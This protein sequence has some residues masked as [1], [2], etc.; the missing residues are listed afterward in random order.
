MRILSVTGVFPPDT[1]TGYANGARDLVEALRRRGHEVRVLAARSCCGDAPGGDGVDRLLRPGVQRVRDWRATV[2]KEAVNQAAFTRVL[3]DFG[4]DVVL[5]FDLSDVS[6]S[7]GMLA[8]EHGVPV[9][10]RLATD[11]FVGWERDDWVRAWPKGA[12]G[13]RA[14]RYAAAKYGLHPPTAPLRFG[15]AIFASSFLAEIAH[16][17]DVPL[18]SSHV[19]PWGVDVDGFP[20][21]PGRAG[22]PLRLLAAGAFE[23]EKGFEVVIRAAARFGRAAGAGG[24]GFALTI[25]GQ[26]PCWPPARSAAFDHLRALVRELGIER[27][28][29]IRPAVPREEM[30]A[31]YRRHDVYVRAD[32]EEGAASLAV[33]EAMSSGLV[34]VARRTQG[35]AD[36]LRDGENAL[37]FDDADAAACAP[38]LSRLAADPGLFEN[39]REAGRRT[40]E[41]DHRLD[42]IAARV[43]RVL[44]EAAGRPSGARVRA[45][46]DRAPRPAAEPATETKAEPPVEAV[47]DELERRVQAEL[48]V[49]ALA[50]AAR[51]VARPATLFRKA[52][53]LAYKISAIGSL[54]VAPALLEAVFRFKG[55]RK[56]AAK[57]DRG[58]DGVKSVL[59]IQPADMGDVLLTSPFLRE[60]RRALP[61]AWIG[62]AVQPSMRAL[63]ERCPYVDEIIPFP[64]RTVPRWNDAFFGHPRW[65]LQSLKV[66]M[67][68]LWKRRIDLAVSVRWNDDA[69]QAAAV[70]LMVASG[71][72]RR[73]GYID[74]PHDRFRYPYANYNRLLTGGPVRRVLKPEAEIQLGVLKWLGAAVEDD[75]AEVWTSPADDEFA[76]AVLREGG[77]VDGEPV[78]AI[79]PGAA[80]APRRWPAERFIE[81]GRRLQDERG[82]RVVLLAAPV[83]RDLAARVAAGLRSDRTLNLAGRTGILQMAAVLRRCRLFLGNDSGPLHLAAAAGVPTVGIYGAGEYERFRPWGTNRHRVV[84]LGLTCSPCSLN[85]IFQDARCLRAIPVEKVWDAVVDLLDQG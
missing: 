82:A 81:V 36:V 31:I 8:R 9:C 25:L 42:E 24:G 43:E 64:W 70:T 34:V 71:A 51:A 73:V 11:W 13:A 56:G 65:W 40:V 21:R 20:F 80:W 23:P 63:V 28:V 84:N 49:A 50:V 83:E 10:S 74:F 38:L 35:G 67:K 6:A 77:I 48:R 44:D 69:P 53:K 68:R 12:G 19:I 29:R 5:A 1:P 41:L 60:L 4:P 47:V 3:R 75:R 18:E 52:R 46:A 14:L 61:K 58:L 30:P 55:L 16:R 22:G 37:L 17:L 26:D 62:L 15:H 66:S 76:A 57:T 78:V 33:L 59:V 85:C 72:R 39:L 2:V 45:G 7:L 32:G 27:E 54:V 79:A